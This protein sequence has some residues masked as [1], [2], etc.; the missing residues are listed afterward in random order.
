MFGVLPVVWPDWNVQQLS[1]SV[2]LDINGPICVQAQ[3]GNNLWRGFKKPIY[4]GLDDRG[5]FVVYCPANG[6]WPANGYALGIEGFDTPGWIQ[7]EEMIKGW[8]DGPREVNYECVL[9]WC[10]FN[11]SEQAYWNLG[12]EN[13]YGRPIK[14]P[15]PSKGGA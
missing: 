4:Y 1:G 12:K 5:Y 2:D 9:D 11:S 10:T 7:G 15:Y 14:V 13:T 6:G 3:G 8:T